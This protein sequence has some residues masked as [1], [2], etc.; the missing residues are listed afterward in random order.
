L[1]A[2]PEWGIFRSTDAGATWQRVS[3]YPSGIFDQPTCMA[4]SWDHFAEVIVGFG[5]N[6]FVKGAAEK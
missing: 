5:G 1:A 3:Y 4:A 6:S 2:S